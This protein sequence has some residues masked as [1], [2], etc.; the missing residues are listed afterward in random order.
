MSERIKTALVLVLDEPMGF[1]E[2]EFKKPA[3]D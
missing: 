1:R 3:P 2:C